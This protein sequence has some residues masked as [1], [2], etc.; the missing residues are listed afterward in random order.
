MLFRSAKRNTFKPTITFMLALLWTGITSAADFGEPLICLNAGGGAYT[1]SQGFQF[2]ADA[3]F[4]GG[5]IAAHAHN[6]AATDDDPLFQSERY[7][8]FSYQI[9]VPTAGSYITTLHF[10]EIYYQSTTTTGGVGSRV[11]D[12]YI[13]GEKV[14]SELDII[15]QAASV[16]A[17]SRS[18]FSQVG[19]SSV[20]ISFGAISDL[21][22]LSAV[23]V[24]PSN[25]DFDGD[26]YSDSDDVFP[27]DGTEWLD[28]DG[29]GIGDNAD[30]F[31]FDATE[32]ADMDG[33]GVGNNSD[34]DMDG[35]GFA[36]DNDAFP[37]DPSEWLDSDN[38]GIGDNSDPTPS[39][40][41]VAECV[42]VGGPEFTAQDGTVFKA[43]THFL[44]GRDR[45]S[46]V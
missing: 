38:D 5:N 2:I 29:D 18:Y 45:K 11:F 27:F 37:E 15:E 1:S 41:S 4:S 46:V 32:S 43:D 44:G 20:N 8:N 36:N 22:K 33:D 25:G 23:C 34:P 7:G 12:V 16:T 30:A 28:S 10:A 40:P 39:L 9:P 17:V 14:E 21:P 3:H 26:G 13:Q 42:N 19:G 31:P 35:D 6:I 24:F